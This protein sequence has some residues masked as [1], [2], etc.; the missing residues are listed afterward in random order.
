VHFLHSLL[1][2]LPGQL[3]SH[4]NLDGSKAPCHGTQQSIYHLYPPYAPLQAASIRSLEPGRSRYFV[5]ICTPVEA[6][7]AAAD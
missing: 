4:G 1:L 5:R 2:L 6:I 7:L 3:R